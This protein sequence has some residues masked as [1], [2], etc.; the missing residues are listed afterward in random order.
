M[1]RSRGTAPVY[2]LKVTLVDSDPPIWRR[3]LVPADMSLARL[4][5]V[6]QVAMGWQDAHLHAF[7]VDGE[8]Y[9]PPEV[10][11]DLET[12]DERKVKLAQALHAPGDAMLYTYD[13][14]DNWEHEVLLERVLSPGEEQGQVPRV[15]EGKR[16]GPPEDVGGVW[17]YDDFLQAIRDPE[18]PEHE[19]Y[20]DWVGEDF[21]PEAF[22][23]QAVNRGLQRLRHTVR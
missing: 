15:T 4:H 17:G 6:L 18:N 21:D 2:Q 11:E 3:I 16:A 8:E 14:G 20:L 19:E 7:N 5:D 13:M 9:A 10:S 22:D 1:V 12:G 23:L